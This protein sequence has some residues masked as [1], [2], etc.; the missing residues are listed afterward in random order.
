MEVINFLLESGAFT[1]LFWLFIIFVFFGLFS[2]GIWLFVKK[3]FIYRYNFAIINH[4]GKLTKTKARMIKSNSGINKFQIKGYERVLLDVQDPNAELDGFPYRVVTYD[5]L[6]W[7]GYV[8]S[9]LKDKGN[10]NSEKVKFK[11]DKKNYLETT[12]VPV[13][14][15][16]LANNIID[17][18]RKHG[19]MPT[20]I[21]WAYAFAFILLIVTIAGIFIQGK[22]LAKQYDVGSEA[23]NQQFNMVNSLEKTAN[24]IKSNTDVQLIILDR[25]IGNNTNYEVIAR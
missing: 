24:I 22:L 9:K 11:V 4:F 17:A 2:W 20:E 19:K 23:T 7:L 16:S 14:R 3:K 13:E 18:T 8:S 15:E 6:G 5:G 1:I 12:L 21:K 10:L 25:I